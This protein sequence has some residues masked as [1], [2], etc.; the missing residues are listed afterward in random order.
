MPLI[1][2]LLNKAE[3]AVLENLR[4]AKQQLA[5]L[6]T[7][8]VRVRGERACTCVYVCL[9]VHVCAHACM[10]AACMCVHAEVPASCEHI[11]GSAHLCCMPACTRVLSVLLLLLLAKRAVLI[12]RAWAY[13]PLCSPFLTPKGVCQRHCSQHLAP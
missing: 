6:T 11:C 4:V 3:V 12:Q 1:D 2:V 8:A 10:R 5:E 9:C 13:I 7:K